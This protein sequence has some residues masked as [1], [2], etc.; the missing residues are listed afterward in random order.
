MFKLG[1][2]LTTWVP[3]IIHTVGLKLNSTASI[4]ATHKSYGNNHSLKFYFDFLVW[5][6]KSCENVSAVRTWLCGGETTASTTKNWDESEYR[7]MDGTCILNYYKC[8]GDVDCLDGDDDTYC[9]TSCT[10]GYNC[11]MYCSSSQ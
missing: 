3:G 5:Y 4:C 2:L 11:S 8:D 7:C 9:A 6:Y 1:L 10:L